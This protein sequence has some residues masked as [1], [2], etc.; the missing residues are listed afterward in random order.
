MEILEKLIMPLQNP[1]DYPLTLDSCASF[2]AYISAVLYTEKSGLQYGDKLLLALFSL[3]CTICKDSDTLSKDTLWEVTTAWQDILIAIVP[4]ISKANLA[5]LTETFAQILNNR[6]LAEEPINIERTVSVVVNFGRCLQKTVPLLTSEMIVTLL[7]QK[8]LNEWKEKINHLCI[9]SE[10]IDGRFCSP[11]EEIASSDVSITEVEIMKFFT[12]SYV[13][14]KVL[15]EQ[16]EESGNEYEDEEDE[17]DSEI[18]AD[19]SSVFVFVFENP[20]E[21]LGDLLHTIC[22]AESCLHNYNVVSNY[23]VLF[24]FSFSLFSIVDE[25]C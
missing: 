24:G 8:L 25:T 19:Q 2:A 22:L 7:N 10:F 15:S 6:L 4:N 21:V 18:Q 11:Y 20:F 14:L 1:D 23:C 3:S 16:L 12:L 5:H 9:W 13:K 17:E